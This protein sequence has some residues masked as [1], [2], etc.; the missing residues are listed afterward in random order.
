V[1][2]AETAASDE[3]DVGNGTFVPCRPRVRGLV[4]TSHFLWSRGHIDDNNGTGCGADNKT[5]WG[6][7][8]VAERLSRFPDLTP[9]IA[10]S[11][12]VVIA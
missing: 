8:N 10:E 5:T 1:H 11:N 4:G 7:E 2:F 12:P 3:F 9:G 6:C